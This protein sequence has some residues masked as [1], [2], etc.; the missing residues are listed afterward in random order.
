MD[1]QASTIEQRAQMRRVLRALVNNAGGG[2]ALAAATRVN[3]G[4]I[5]K[6]L[7]DHHPE[8]MPIDVVLDAMILSG[9]PV[10]LAYL[11]GLIG[12][13]VREAGAAPGA[14]ITHAHA[15]DLMRKSTG[16]VDTIFEALV[17]QI[18]T[19]SESRDIVNA[20]NGIMK[21]AQDALRALGERT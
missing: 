17:D 10:L 19:G 7:A 15:M 12:Y 2:K 11:A 5:S 9:S 20:L 1:E 18:V 6:C 16:A 3:E 13:E 8:E 21:A 14:G 4:H